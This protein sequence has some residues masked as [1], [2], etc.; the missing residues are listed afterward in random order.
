MEASTS[1]GRRD[2]RNGTIP[3][4][5]LNDDE[6]LFKLHQS[7]VGSNF[8][9]YDSI[10]VNVKNIDI[11][12]ITTWSE[13]GDISS[14]EN[15]IQR[16]SYDKLTP[17]QRYTIPVA[18]Q[19][20]NLIVSAQ[21]GSGKTAAFLFPTIMKMISEGPPS[22]DR[23][24]VGCSAPIAVILSPTRELALQSYEEARKFCAGTGIRCAAIYGGGT[25]TGQQRT[26]CRDGVDIISAC[27]GKFL[28]FLSQNLIDLSFVQYFIIDEADRMLDQGFDADIETIFQNPQLN[29]EKE[30]LMFSATFPPQIQALANR[31]LTAP[32][33]ITIGANVGDTV[34]FIEQRF[35]Q[36]EERDKRVQL[37]KEL[38]NMTGKIDCFFANSLRR[39]CNQLLLGTTPNS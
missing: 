29:N 38:M 26:A 3:Q 37:Y 10:P 24:I 27:T 17:V 21:T 18:M 2:N 39:S 7:S 36:C 15:N 35:V 28:D 14:I 34:N 31:Y 6:K 32:A 11:L 22:Q 5:Y 23:D 20:R 33:S 13:V 19:G 4:N 16:L 8:D 25:N 12:P 9:Y 30:V 1:W